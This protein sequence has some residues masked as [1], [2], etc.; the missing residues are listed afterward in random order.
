MFS[1]CDEKG[2]T[3]CRAIIILRRHYYFFLYWFCRFTHLHLYLYCLLLGTNK[4]MPDILSEIFTQSLFGFSVGFILALKMKHKCTHTH[5]GS[6]C[7]S[8]RQSH[9]FI[10][11]CLKVVSQHENTVSAL[12]CQLVWM[13]L[14]MVS[15]SQ[16]AQIPSQIAWGC[17][18]HLRPPSDFQSNK[19]ITNIQHVQTTASVISGLRAE[20]LLVLTRDL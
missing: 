5:H 8:D 15:L 7:L 12:I 18:A 9:V 6:F 17:T 2:R 20:L 13:G 14:K 4:N 16:Q 19:L 11:V 3:Y 1:L 10:S